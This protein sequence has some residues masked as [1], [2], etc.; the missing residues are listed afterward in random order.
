MHFLVVLLLLYM[1]KSHHI[2]TTLIEQ[3]CAISN[4][5]GKNS[6]LNNWLDSKLTCLA[7]FN[8]ESLKHDTVIDFKL[9][10]C[11]ENPK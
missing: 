2:L 10:R 5:K 6:R 1:F 7:F 9:N 3:M 8:I 4:K 11:D